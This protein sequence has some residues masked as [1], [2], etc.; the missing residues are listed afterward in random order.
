MPCKRYTRSS[1]AMFPVA[2][3]AK[4]QPPVPPTEASSTV[5]P[6]S[7]AA[8]AFAIPVLRVSWKWQPTVA[9]NASTPSTSSH[10]WLGTPTP[11]VSASKISSGFATETFSAMPSTCPGST[12][13]SKGSPKAALRVMETRTPSTRALDEASGKLCRFC[14]GRVL[15]AAREGLGHGEGVAHL[16]HTGL[17]RPLVALLIQDEASV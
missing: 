5:A 1:V 4:G 6:D 11:M 16:V 8:A 2:R 14:H 12:R 9:P 7:T 13:P 15:V 17:D 3:G 10:T